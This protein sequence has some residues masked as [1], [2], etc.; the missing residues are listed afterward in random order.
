[1]RIQTLSN[2]RD[3][4]SRWLGSGDSQATQEILSAI[5]TAINDKVC[6]NLGYADT[7]RLIVPESVRLSKAGNILI[8]A[9]RHLDGELVDRR[10]RADR[11]QSVEIVSLTAQAM[12]SG[13]LGVGLIE[14]CLDGGTRT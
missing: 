1:M 9:K 11:I 3:Y 8:E 4:P 2:G 12:I 14:A 6:L 5:G 10:Y 7:H 13:A